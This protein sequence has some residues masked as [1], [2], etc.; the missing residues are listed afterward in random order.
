MSKTSS[1][2][3]VVLAGETCGD[4]SRKTLVCRGS[5]ESFL[6]ADVMT[7]GF[8]IFDVISGDEALRFKFSGELRHLSA[9]LLLVSVTYLPSTAE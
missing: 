8:V 9:I 2:S 6:V 1:R 5:S 7:S 4:V 3:F